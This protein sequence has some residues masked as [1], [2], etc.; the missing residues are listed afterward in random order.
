MENQQLATELSDLVSPSLS[1]GTSFR[2][3][4]K[5]N[6]ETMLGNFALAFCDSSD[7]DKKILEQ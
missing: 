1:M 7:L 4:D 2:A 6:T 3:E 5:I